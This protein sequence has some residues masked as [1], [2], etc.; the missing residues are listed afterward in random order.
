MSTQRGSGDKS[1]VQNVDNF[2][3][4]IRISFT[5]HC[6]VT[7]E[8]ISQIPCHSPGDCKIAVEQNETYTFYL[9]FEY[10]CKLHLFPAA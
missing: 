10:I 1:Q 6:I 9:A 5:G 3:F 7:G 8:E 2:A 4:N